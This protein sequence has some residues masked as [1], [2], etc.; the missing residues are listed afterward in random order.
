MHLTWAERTPDWEP[1]ENN[2][3]AGDTFLETRLGVNGC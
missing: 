2:G 3:F 1:L